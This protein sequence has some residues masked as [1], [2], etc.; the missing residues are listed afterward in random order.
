M[1]SGIKN[2]RIL[3]L[4][5]LMSMISTFTKAQINIAFYPL[6]EQFNSYNLN[7]AFL[8]P[9]N[10]FTFSIFPMGGTSIGYNNQLVIRQLVTKFLSGG[11][12]DQDYRDILKSMADRSSFN[13]SVES[14]LLSFTYRSDFG[15]FNFRVKENESFSISMKGSL[16]DFVI[17]TGIQ[18]AEINQVQN[19]PAQALHYRE[20]S[21]GYTLPGNHHR[22]TAGIRA[23]LYF[24]KGAFS[25][26]L[27]G[28]IKKDGANYLL[29][30]QGKV[31]ISVPELN[32]FNTDGTLNSVSLFGG[33]KTISY[34]MN[35]GNPGFGVDLGFKYRITPAL[36]VS[37][38]VIDL[39][40]INWKSN[41]NSKDLVGQYRIAGST[42]NSHVSSNGTELITKKFDNNSSISDSINN[43]FHITYDHSAFTTTLPVSAYAG[44]KYQVSPAMN[45]NLMDKYV[46]INKMS[47]NSILASASMV[48]NK[49]LTVNAGYAVIG[50]SYFNIPV[51]LLF[52]K[53]FGQIYVGTDNLAAFILPSISE[54][55]GFTF[56]TCFYLFRKRDLSK[57]TDEYFPFFRPRK[58]KKRSNGLIL[59]EYP[60]S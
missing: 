26:G 56:G 14:T 2:T 27:S 57:P 13:Q 44:L 35:R 28:T 37:A 22:F 58:I 18:T 46:I 34:L 10:R 8:N 19:L 50:N 53:D 55:A 60:E 7:P 43:L 59:K 38:S 47:Y 36:S 24:G 4:L 49:K 21:L 16:T 11:T 42:V 52:K 29:Q 12:T 30:A 20:Y 23:K 45:I 54:F 31:L 33:S 6:E 41:L 1:K 17:R 40:K 51:A 39:G 3:V 15:N 25:S 5:T 9:Q 48:V 32:A